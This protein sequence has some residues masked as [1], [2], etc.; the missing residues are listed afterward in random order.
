MRTS[1]KIVL[2][3]STPLTIALIIGAYF[4]S[5]GNFNNSPQA[6]QDG[7]SIIAVGFAASI[8][9]GIFAI[10]AKVKVPNF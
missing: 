6:H 9:A 1:V 4:I 8:M 3:A 10:I 7:W 2:S 5:V